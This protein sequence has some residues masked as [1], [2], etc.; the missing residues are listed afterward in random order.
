[1]SDAVFGMAY[2][3]FTTTD[4][5]GRRGTCLGWFSTKAA[6]GRGWYGGDGCVDESD[7]ITVDGFMF[8]LADKQPVVINDVDEKQ[9]AIRQRLLSAMSEEERHA[10]GY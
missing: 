5:F 3:A 10:L 1:M 2:G 9:E 6:K 4:E 8:R 7:T